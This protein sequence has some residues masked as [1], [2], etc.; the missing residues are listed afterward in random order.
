MTDYARGERLRFLREERRLSQIEA[1][2]ESGFSDRTI[3]SW[4]H[5]GRIRWANA[6]RYAK[7]Y[8]VEPESVVTR[9]LKPPVE[10]EDI[11]EIKA[12]LAELTRQRPS[13]QPGDED[14]EENADE[15]ARREA[16]SD[17]DDQSQTG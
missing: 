7:F 17:E 13:E 6:K 3:R 11:E 4:E 12:Q 14:G 10:P 9:D 8:G 5:G 2:Y 1:A 15:K 16:E